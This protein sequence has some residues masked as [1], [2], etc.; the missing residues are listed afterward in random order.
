MKRHRHSRCSCGSSWTQCRDAESRQLSA[1]AQLEKETYLRNQA[2]D[3]LEEAAA[4]QE[5]VQ[6]KL[7]EATEKH[8]AAKEEQAQV[9]ES[10]QKAQ[11]TLAKQ[12]DQ[13]SALQ[14]EQAA[15]AEQRAQLKISRMELEKD[16]ESSSRDSS[17]P[18]NS[19]CLRLR[20]IPRCSRN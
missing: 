4:H 8:R 5:A 2:A 10:I 18:W 6:E 14:E 11:E 17:S 16:L 7:R 19:V 13:R 9:Q 20:Q 15:L 1:Q 12:S 3:R